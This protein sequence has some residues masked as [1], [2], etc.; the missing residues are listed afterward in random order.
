M[1]NIKLLFGSCGSVLSTRSS[2]RYNAMCRTSEG[3][4]GTDFLQEIESCASTC[5][6][7]VHLFRRFGL[8][9]V[10][11]DLDGLRFSGLNRSFEDVDNSTLTK[12]SKRH[13]T[14]SF[15]RH[16]IVGDCVQMFLVYSISWSFHQHPA[17][18]CT[19][20]TAPPH[21]S[22]SSHQVTQCST[23]VQSPFQQCIEVS[24]ARFALGF[25]TRHFSM[26]S[27]AVWWRRPKSSA[28]WPKYIARVFELSL[29][30]FAKDAANGDH[31][32]QFTLFLSVWFIFIYWIV[33]GS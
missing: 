1:P 33:R 6:E 27:Q 5:Y 7:H 32:H 9:D 25:S 19:T 14:S 23:P 13:E 30:G 21:L 12:I 26:A 11:K 28:T 2:R 10:G 16:S 17:Y 20:A 4:I 8:F 31:R 24:A 15:R 29:L 18:I 3:W 22:R